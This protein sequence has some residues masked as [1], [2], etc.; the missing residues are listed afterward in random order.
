MAESEYSIAII[1]MEGRFPKANNV[2]N[3]WE[4]LKNARDCIDRDESLDRTDF[5]GAYG[6]VENID[7]FDA[8]FFQV[9]KTE[10]LDSDP[11]Q[12]VML[13]IAY[14]AMENA[15]YSNEKYDG[16]VGTFISY[17]YGAYI[18]NIIM[19]DPDDWYKRYEIY[20]S[21]IAT[22]CEKIAYKLGF[23][24]PA[25]MSQYSCAS[26]MNTVHEACQSLLNFECD[27]AL[28]GGISLATEQNGYDP[29]L[30][31]ESSK[32]IICPFDRDAD[33][34]V[35]G[36]AGGVVV[37]KR[38]EEAVEDHDHIIAIIKGTFLNNDGKRKAGFAAPSVYGQEECL[39]SVLEISE[40]EPEEINYYE[41]H[42]T[43]TELG[44]SIELR[45]IKNVIGLRETDNKVFIGSVKANIGHTDMAAGICNVIKTALILKERTL[46]PSIH[47]KNP[48]AELNGDENPLQVSVETR[49]WTGKEPM[50][51]VASS[52]GLGGANAMAVM[53]EHCEQEERN[54]ENPKE[55][56]LIIFS[57]K[58]EEAVKQM[59]EELSQ[60]LVDPKIR[61]DDAA[62]TL[63]TG[64]NYFAYRSFGI[65][66]GEKRK[67]S[68]RRVFH[69][70][71]EMQKQIVFAFSGVGSFERTVG[72]ELYKSNF[73]FRQQMD[74]CFL[75]CEEI[76]V[77]G[78]KEYYLNFQ[79]KKDTKIENDNV[80]GMQLLFCV[81][82]SMAKTLMEFGI[83]PQKVI[84]HS[85]GEYIA[86]AI[87]GI[88]Q[89]KDA[90]YLLKRRSELI[91][92]I[93]E[94]GMINIA[95]NLENVKKMLVDGVEIGA[96]NAPNRIMVTG[97][98]Q[99]IEKFEKKLKTTDIVYRKMEVN[100]AGHCCL[101]EEILEEYREI[102]SQITFH[103]PN[104]PIVSS[105]IPEC[106]AAKEMQQ[107]EYWLKQM[108]EKV[109]FYDAVTS[110][111]DN[112]ESLFVEIG[113]SDALATSIRNMRFG[114]ESISTFS[115]FDS[116]TATNAKNGFLQFLGDMW[117]NGIEIQWEK[118]YQTKPYRIP[119]THY[120]FEHKKYWKYRSQLNMGKNS[121]LEES[122]AIY[123]G[124]TDL[125]YEK[126]RYIAERTEGSLILME[127]LQEQYQNNKGISYMFSSIDKFLECM[128]EK[129]FQ[130]TEITLL[131]EID[132]YVE[133][134]N[135]LV[136]A[137][138]L[139]YF[140]TS[141]KFEV[142]EV[143][144]IDKFLQLYRVVE[145]YI[146]FIKYFVQFLKDYGYLIDNYGILRFSEKAKKI[147]SKYEIL[148]QCRQKYPGCC[149]YMEFCVYVSEHYVDVFAGKEEGSTVIYPEG[150]FTLINKYE[151]KMP[152]YSYIPNCI[153]ALAEAVET[154]VKHSERKL[155]ILEIGAGSGEM[156]DMLLDKLK[157]EQLEYWFT[158]IKQSL[159]ME[160]KNNE[161]EE[162]RD[163]MH[164]GV[165]DI[166][167]NPEKQGYIPRS[168]DIVL[169]YDVI[170]ATTDM[171][172]TVKNIRSLLADD[173]M[174]AFVQTCD[175][176]EWMNMIYGFAPGWW[177][178]DRDPKRNRIT[179]PAQ[180]WKQVLQN[181]GFTNTYSLPNGNNSNA[182][183]FIMQSNRTYNKEN[184]VN[185][186]EKDNNYKKL[187]KQHDEIEVVFVN[188]EDKNKLEEIAKKHGAQL[189]LVSN[190]E[191]DIKIDQ[192]D[193]R[194]QL[195]V[196][197]KHI[198]KEVIGYDVSL[199]ED[200]YNLGM[201]SLM[202]MMISSK[203]QNKLR[204]KIQLSDMYNLT[205]VKEISDFL[206]HAEQVEEVEEI[207][208]IAEPEKNLEDLLNEL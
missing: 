152:K 64:R 6:K 191:E 179:M 87:S 144:T 28:A 168:Y 34:L 69:Y 136:A 160:R 190:T 120:P 81:G 154:A 55:A 122:V 140:R 185:S 171:T 178:Y 181:C 84:G 199:D 114:S 27:I 157:G 95:T 125:E 176:S 10:A 109:M 139:D 96:I 137:C 56:Q 123:Q 71:K 147:S 161:P 132:G 200:L 172:K 100:R 5:I 173:G 197:V 57:G 79:K 68:R 98:K 194:N 51:A 103:E 91:E 189:V 111:Q 162:N 16:K 143:Y 61:L 59:R 193:V 158:D 19:Q 43:A 24:G 198:V 8:D 202:A 167:H 187:M 36:S 182:Y 49:K 107:I 149:A 148:E 21:Y 135:T 80:K 118:L 208:E 76:G 25:I 35:P 108:R 183:L 97:E 42:G 29:T 117:S 45:A 53:G 207:K 33:G 205:S 20:K 82:Y 67:L 54:Q 86:A 83:R 121:N 99:E 93:P 15:G 26:S 37:L 131:R 186:I 30:T 65:I 3:F 90:L 115:C 78:M 2:E 41:A 174:F 177:N 201:D 40:V 180:Q 75:Y 146:P 92:K 38:Y 133:M 94:G 60:K 110:I 46:V 145:K 204:L 39:R 32:G 73:I 166:S 195:D 11:E 74:Q 106:D 165:L 101:V 130:N 9:T 206:S 112:E 52:I 155:R 1:G 138:I 63:Q 105:C 124:L 169:L 62:Y 164:Y 14:H 151:A 66:D 188:T 142:D 7:E 72:Q 13:E 70:D 175:G 163:F 150:K 47:Y 196:D 17:D 134:S 128:E 159:V 44:D 58:T 153:K 89:V 48:C 104:I 156:T 141:E 203:I 12:R 113:T 119:L 170:Q 88:L 102:L 4:N 85:N 22:R 116:P 192:S 23:T 18:W 184:V 126:T 127:P 77:S 129:Y 50:L 31:T